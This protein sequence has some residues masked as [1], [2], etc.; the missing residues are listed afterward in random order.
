MSLLTFWQSNRG[1]IQ[2]KHIQ[3]LVA[4]AGDG[5]LRDESDTCRELRQ[6]LAA[7]PTEV[8]GQYLN[9]CLSASFT[10][11]GFVLQ[12]LVNELGRRLGCDVEQGSYRGKVGGIGYDG[13]WRFPGGY[14]IVVEVKTTDA[15]TIRL[16][17]L[18]EYRRKLNKEDRI[19]ED[20]SV[21][22]VVGRKDTDSLEAQV[23]GSRHAWDMRLISADKLLKLVQLKENADSNATIDKIRT[24]LTPLELTKVDF[25]V[26]LLATTAEDLGG[27]LE[28]EL[29]QEEA[30][31]KGREKKFTPVAFNSGIAETV[32]AHLG[33]QFAKQT[34]SLFVNPDSRVSVRCLA[35]RS[36][37]AGGKTGFWYA[38]HPYY[39][40]EAANYG[41]N[42]VAFGCGA[43]ERVILFELDEFAQGLGSLNTTHKEDR[44]YW[45]VQFF[46]LTGG[47][48]RLVQKG[49]GP[50][51]DVTQKKLW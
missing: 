23:R 37:E 38:F 14:A 47:E 6:Y 20:S 22:I 3:Q 50:G 49:G 24:V 11:S 9:E 25:I 35:S 21:L 42:Y 45:H 7:V 27:D 33:L 8:L 26:D 41:K 31:A 1:D 16:D 28:E 17:T 4:L 32:G 5:N 10:G 2:G 29:E 12:D 39:L 40:E 19:T 34:R 46:E 48:V 44:M 43:P 13:I 18:A 30:G 36:Y 15:Y 51:I